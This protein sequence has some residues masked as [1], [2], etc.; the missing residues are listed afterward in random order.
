MYECSNGMLS[1]QHSPESGVGRL[2]GALHDCVL[3]SNEVIVPPILQAHH[4]TH[5]PELG[6][7]HV[8]EAGNGES[9]D[10]NLNRRKFVRKTQV[11]TI[12]LPLL[13]SDGLW[14]HTGHLP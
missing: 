3:E 12:R 10:E 5:H 1:S 6:R 9:P 8:A 2:N 7:D 11:T 14:L 13:P 4:N